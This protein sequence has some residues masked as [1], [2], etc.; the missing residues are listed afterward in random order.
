M[1]DE[2]LKW[3]LTVDLYIFHV[4]VLSLDATSSPSTL[5]SLSCHSLPI[6]STT[7]R[8]A[9][10][11][12]IIATFRTL[13]HICIHNP[14]LFMQTPHGRTSMPVIYLG[15]INTNPDER[16]SSHFSIIDMCNKNAESWYLHLDKTLIPYKTC[17]TTFVFY[18]TIGYKLINNHRS[19]VDIFYLILTLLDSTSCRE[20]IYS[21]RQTFSHFIYISISSR[22]CS[23]TNVAAW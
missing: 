9:L 10:V 23:S 14:P 8:G 3:Q 12:R 13:S 20:S 19:S 18:C 17:K 5:L 21:T 7:V 1:L 2:F 6:I 4:G 11:V 16:V 15:T 22:L